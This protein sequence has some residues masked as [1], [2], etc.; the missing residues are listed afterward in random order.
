MLNHDLTKIFFEMAQYLD[1]E[2]NGTAS[3][4]KSIAFKKAAGNLETL[5]DDVED[6]YKK[7]ELK[8]LMEIPVIGAFVVLQKPDLPER[9]KQSP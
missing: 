5:S 7:G 9:Q 3:H 4:F 2:E 1:M 8:A 6:I